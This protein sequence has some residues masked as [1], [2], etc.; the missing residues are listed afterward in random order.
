MTPFE[1]DYFDNQFLPVRLSCAYAEDSSGQPSEIQRLQAQAQ[2]YTLSQFSGRDADL[3]VGE[4]RVGRARLQPDSTLIMTA[5]EILDL[6]Q[7]KVK[8]SVTLGWAVLLPSAL[9]LSEGTMV[10]MS[11]A[12][13][14]PVCVRFA[15]QLSG[16]AT[17]ELVLIDATMG[18]RLVEM[19]PC[20]ADQPVTPNGVVTHVAAGSL[21]VEA[22][23]LDQ[24]GE[25][26]ILRLAQPVTEPFRLMSGALPIA[27][28]YLRAVLPGEITVHQDWGDAG[29]PDPNEARV[30]FVV[31]RSLLSVAASPRTVV[32]ESRG[33]HARDDQI[34][35]RVPVQFILSV[36]SGNRIAYLIEQSEPFLAG[37]LLNVLAG[38]DSEAASKQLTRVLEQ[39]RKDV[40]VNFSTC[41]PTDAE[42]AVWRIVGERLSRLLSPEELE[43]AKTTAQAYS[44]R[45]LGNS[46]GMPEVPV[47]TAAAVLAGVPERLIE[48]LLKELRTHSPELAA[49]LRDRLFFF[50][51]ISR[52]D[53]RAISKILRE[54]STTELVKALIAAK[55][56][57]KEAIVRNISK[58][59]SRI[60]E[61]EIRYA[62]GTGNEAI[63]KSRLR[64]CMIAKKLSNHGEIVL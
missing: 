51:D 31:T 22:C 55:A 23:K 18:V 46:A 5:G 43:C 17:G 58:R 9:P 64:V 39:N 11:Y 33:S 40:V 8:I 26:T 24:V 49:G 34:D 37:W 2:V 7:L 41:C 62:S 10:V 61:D 50:D 52:L 25:E 48:P 59:A 60:L 3:W 38:I 15:G 27:E 32:S 30:A 57:T 54:I 29:P 45:A 56:E 14:D 20:E 13:G 6:N 4:S 53:D 19:T 12:I 1:N 35:S 28:G 47:D 16:W 42:P 36:L 21:L 63:D 44:Y